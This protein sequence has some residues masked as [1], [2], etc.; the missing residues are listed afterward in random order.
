[1][2]TTSIAVSWI[3]R[4]AITVAAI[5]SVA[6]ITMLVMYFQEIT[7]PTLVMAVSLYGLPAAFI[8]GGVVVTYNIRQRR[9]D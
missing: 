1:M 5:S 2:S 4:I 8:L 3:S 7:I 9:R 6:L